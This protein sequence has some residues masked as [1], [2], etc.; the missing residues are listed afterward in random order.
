MSQVGSTPSVNAEIADSQIS[1]DTLSKVESHLAEAFG[2]S[3]DAGS[4]VLDLPADR[5]S[6]RDLIDDDI[7]SGSNRIYRQRNESVSSRSNNR[8]TTR[9]HAVNQG[10]DEAGEDEE[11]LDAIND[12]AG[13]ADNSTQDQTGSDE[14]LP[15]QGESP[16]SKNDS[17]IPDHLIAA[18][19]RRGRT[20]DDISRLIEV[21]S[22]IAH[23]TFERDLQDANELSAR[24]AS[25]GRAEMQR[26]NR[27]GEIAGGQPGQ[28]SLQPVDSLAPIAPT[29]TAPAAQSY[30]QPTQTNQQSSPLMGLTFDKSIHESVEP[31]FSKGVLAPLEQFSA[32][33]AQQVEALNQ[34]SRQTVDHIQKNQRDVEVARMDQFFNKQEHFADFYGVD[35]HCSQL[36]KEQADSRDRVIQTAD[37]IRTG[38]Y[39]QGEDMTETQALDMAHDLVTAKQQ[40]QSVR[41]E[42]AGQ[43]VDRDRRAT[44]RPS[45][46]GG[47][48]DTGSKDPYAKAIATAE[49]KMR[50]IGLPQ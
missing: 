49:R 35:K 32:H 30:V 46:R 12:R 40:R 2:G 47:G 38:S 43:V 29:G 31:E 5:A 18:A 41:R 9:Q 20:D 25:L 22:D 3:G 36:S 15:G 14:T 21:D 26:Q 13:E 37:A 8:P 28:L 42:I 33:L 27:I 1:E 19:R 24:F 44:M 4:D 6:N 45:R 10:F 50:T 11:D 16:T 7:N 17:K 34:A 39:I 48:V 23:R